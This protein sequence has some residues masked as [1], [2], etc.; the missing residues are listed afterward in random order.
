MT[1][2]EFVEYVSMHSFEKYCACCKQWKGSDQE[3]YSPCCYEMATTSST[4]LHIQ[5]M[6]EDISANNKKD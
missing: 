2:K 4:L 1:P 6:A 3:T 5:M